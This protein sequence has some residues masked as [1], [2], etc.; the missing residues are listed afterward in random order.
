M[1]QWQISKLLERNRRAWRIPG[2]QGRAAHRHDLAL[3]EQQL[4]LCAG[5]YRIAE[6]Q[7]GVE[8]RIAE[9]ERLGAY[10]QIHGDIRPQRAKLRQARDQPLAGQRRNDRYLQNP[11]H[12]ALRHQF[13]RIALNPVEILAHERRVITAMRG[14]HNP[15]LDAQEQSDAQAAFQS[16]NLA[17]YRALRERE[18]IGGPGEALVAR[19]G[20]EDL[21]GDQI[22]NTFSHVLPVPFASRIEGIGRLLWRLS[23]FY[24]RSDEFISIARLFAAVQN[25]L[26]V[27]RRTGPWARTTLDQPELDK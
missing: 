24:E 25:C 12:T 19:G 5:P 14:Q 8:G 9:Q 21:Q 4:P 13:E 27:N 15:L 18:F 17:A 3:A 6:I 26:P 22:G 10:R 7:R 11:P 16:R 20:L 23:S 1:Q 2:E